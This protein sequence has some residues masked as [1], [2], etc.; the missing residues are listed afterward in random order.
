[1]LKKHLC[2]FVHVLYI[3]FIKNVS[4]LIVL[5]S[6]EFQDCAT[7]GFYGKR[8]SSRCPTNCLNGHCNRRGECLGCIRGHQGVRCDKGQSLFVCLSHSFCLS[9]SSYYLS[10]SLSVSFCL[11]RPLSVY[12]SLPVY[13]SIFLSLCLCIYLFIYISV[14]L[15]LS[16]YL[17]LSLSL[18]LILSSSVYLWS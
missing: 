16:L 11:A 6:N 9:L 18:C 5:F 12:L 10:F 14:S 13:I 15:C 3:V 2:S 8:C 1:M 17:S 4:V 7:P